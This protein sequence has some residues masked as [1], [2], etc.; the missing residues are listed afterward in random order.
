MHLGWVRCMY[1]SGDT[2]HP[3]RY[4]VYRFAISPHEDTIIHLVFGD[5]RTYHLVHL[6]LIHV[7]TALHSSITWLHMR[8]ECARCMHTS[9]DTVNLASRHGVCRHASP[10]HEDSIIHLAFGDG[11]AYISVNLEFMYIPTSI[12]SFTAWFHTHMEWVRYM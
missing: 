7:L 4:G 9:G 12:Q 5:E 3:T 11:W 2:V 8:M 6:A 10:P 1:T